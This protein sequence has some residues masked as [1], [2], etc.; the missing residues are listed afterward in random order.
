[1]LLP[2]IAF[3]CGLVLSVSQILNDA[4]ADDKPWWAWSFVFAGLALAQL[5]WGPRWP[6][7][8]P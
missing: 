7:S 1:M 6:R 4:V 5:P 8:G 3:I 2:F